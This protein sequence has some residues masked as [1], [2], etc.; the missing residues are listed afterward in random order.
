MRPT[1]PSGADFALILG[2]EIIVMKMV[3]KKCV[4]GRVLLSC[5]W[6]L[7]RL[8]RQEIGQIGRL[9]PVSILLAAIDW[10]GSIAFEGDRIAVG[11][12]LSVPDFPRERLREGKTH[13]GAFASDT[14]SSTNDT[15]LLLTRLI[16]RV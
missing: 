11:C 1:N 4:V 6:P 13:D 5:G 2:D 9:K 10:D 3:R 16:Q 15:L 8:G 12:Y 7:Q 14:R